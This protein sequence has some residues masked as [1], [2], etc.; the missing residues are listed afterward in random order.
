[1]KSKYREPLHFPANLIFL[2]MPRSRFPQRQAARRTAAANLS[3]QAEGG[4][5][6]RID[7][8][9]A[10]HWAAGVGVAQHIYTRSG[11]PT[12]GPVRINLRRSVVV[13]ISGYIKDYD[14]RVI[15]APS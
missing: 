10:A 7:E 9:A 13:K 12:G 5:A 2:V 1:M 4:V 14:F 6:D 3:I 8:D 15:I 11:G